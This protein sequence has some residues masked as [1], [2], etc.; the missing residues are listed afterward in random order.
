[1]ATMSDP[2][3]IRGMTL[4]NRFVRSATWE[5]MCD[6][7]GRPPARLADFYRELARGGVGL[8]ISGYAFV[9]PEGKQLPGQMG[10]H[11]DDHEA[12]HRALT[13]AVHDE[14]GRI[15]AQIVHAGGQTNAEAAGCRPVA[16]S[17]VEMAQFAE[18]PAEL[19]TVDIDEIVAAFADAA[20][21]ARDWG[22][23]AVQ[24]HGAHGYLMG[25]F[26]SPLTNVRTDGYGGGF[27]GRMRFPRE[28][29]R[30]VRDAVGDDYPVLIKLNGEDHLDGGIGIEEAVLTATDLCGLGLDA[31]EVSGGTPASGKRGP[32]RPAINAPEKE[33]YHLAAARRI[34]TAVDCP[35]LAVGGF[36]TY[37]VVE[38]A[39]ADDGV[40]GIALSRPLIRE[41]DL[42]GR[43]LAGERCKSACVSCGKCFI[44]GLKEGAIACVVARRAK[45]RAERGD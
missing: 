11:R 22:Y 37:E 17:A 30:A 31:I 8:I 19:T 3:T 43:W 40:D 10:L 6:V 1:M 29:V 13:E 42:P 36:R 5:G 4:P 20:R 7:D 28:V 12:D 23:D 9:R 33:G 27:D 39:L 14:G 41:P 45:E 16:P 32:A 25:Q 15:A 2:L 18:V 44:P 38:A 21:R 24:L 35:V 34:K 26:L